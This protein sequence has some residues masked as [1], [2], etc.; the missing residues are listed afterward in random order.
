MIKYYTPLMMKS[1]NGSIVNIGSIVGSCG[2]YGQTIYSATKSGLIGVTKT[3]SKE[4]MKYNIRVNIVEPGFTDTSMTKNIPL[5]IK[6]KYM[7]LIGMKRLA[8]P[9]EIA[10]PIV[11]LCSDLSSYITGQILRIDGGMTM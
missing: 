1:N 5:K 2:N 11:F 10:N 4:L 8:S 3:Q 7:D 9:E 6:N